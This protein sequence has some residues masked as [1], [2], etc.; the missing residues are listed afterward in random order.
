[1]RTAGQTRATTRANRDVV[2][3]ADIEAIER[4]PYDGL[5]PARNLY[6]L[7][8]ATAEL[9]PYRPALTVLADGDPGNAVRYTHAELRREIARA[10]NMFRTSFGVTPNSGTI[11]FLCTALPQIPAALLGAQV[12]GV[13]SSINYLLSEDAIADLLAAENASVLV[14]PSEDQDASLWKKAN[15]VVE[16][17]PSIESVLVAGGNEG[18]RGKYRCLGAELAAQSDELAFPLATDR[19]DICALFHTG[20]TTGRPK[21]VRLTHGNQIHAAWSFAQ[22]HGLDERD[23]AING[24]PLF[25][26]GGTITA[27]LSFLAAGGHVI[28]PSAYSLRS[29]EVIQNYWNIVAALGATIVSGVPT[30]IAALAEVPIGSA[31]IQSVR[32]GLTGGSVC[33]KAV[34]DRFSLRTGITLYETYGMTETA[35]AIA[36]NPGRGQ[37]N[38]GS[39]G[40]RAPFAT[41]RI[42]SLADH[43]KMQDCPA[44]TSGL[45]VVKGPQVFPGYVD[46]KHNRGVLT[47]DGWLIT[48]DVGY[49]TDDQRLVLTGR[50]KDLIVRSGHNIDPAAIE[51]VANEFPGVQMSSAVGMP[52]VYAG[53]VPILFVVPSPGETIDV[54][55]LRAHVD[56]KINEPPAKPKQVIVLDAL[57]VTAVGKI[58]KPAL[59][60]LAIRERVRLEVS[61]IFGGKTRHSVEVDRD[62]KLNTIVRVSIDTTDTALLQKLADSL[63]ALPQSYVV[64]QID[65]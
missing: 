21:L 29:K 33:P 62:D 10:A 53:E 25:H 56:R 51:D 28:I 17:L 46:P 11:A 54:D 23:V 30:S 59:R 37:P 16:R 1:M 7:F 42:V 49:L 40:F 34:S 19:S 50:E 52:D 5:I 12:A 2:T 41:T 63:S 6:E 27:G 48:G 44:L 13:A 24:F 22:V 55:R 18:L 32:M 45:V 3:I 47:D 60:D 31:D 61:A 20:G 8:Q 26:V 58:F 36:F 15:S 39:V 14:V 64:R 9:H 38:Q 57:P 43:E 4:E 65:F 35:A